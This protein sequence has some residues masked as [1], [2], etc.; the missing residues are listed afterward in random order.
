MAE[1]SEA[2]EECRKHRLS[3]AEYEQTLGVTSKMGLKSKS[4]NGDDECMTT[5]LT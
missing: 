3:I 2:S 4:V 5:F 1:T